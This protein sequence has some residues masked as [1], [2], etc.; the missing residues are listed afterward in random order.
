MERAASSKMQVALLTAAEADDALSR[1][2][3]AV[4]PWTRS[5]AVPTLLL[6][7]EGCPT[8]SPAAGPLHPI[9]LAGPGPRAAVLQ[10]V[11]SL[12]RGPREK[13][14]KSERLHSKRIC[15]KPKN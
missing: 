4:R 1:W 5:G 3:T 12:E 8:A 14:I 7:Q 6:S 15:N 10:C 11:Q 9:G 13:S 2:C